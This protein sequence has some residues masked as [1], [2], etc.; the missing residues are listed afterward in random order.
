M[1]AVA[2]KGLGRAR[3]LYQDRTQ[4]AKELKAEGKL[5]IGYFCLY[6][7]L[8]ML[9]ALDIVPY[10]IFGSMA[11]PITRAD[12]CL[13]TV[14]CPFVRSALD[15][16]LKGKYD[17]L[18]GVVMC[19]SCEVAEKS[20]HIWRTF[21]NPD[22]FYFIDAPH[23][24]HQ[25]AQEQ[26]K[27][28][29]KG[30]QKTLESLTGQKLTTA[31]LKEAVKT[32]NQQRS[33]V[34]ELYDLTKPDPPLISGAE[35]M[36]VMVSLT[37]LPIAEGSELLRQV[38]AEVKER[39]NGPA[40]KPARLLLWGSIIDD[41]ALIEMIENAG[42]HIVVDDTC[43]GSRAHFDDVALTDDPLDGLAHRYLVDIKCPRTF[44]DF[45]ESSGTSME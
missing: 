40:Q 8:E 19:H 37:G 38:I 15:L 42:A 45:G 14:V 2:Q 39:Q 35:T 10:R 26:F 44:R 41:T 30:F 18:N 4:R 6:P 5:V 31:S 24:V 22:Y 13:P 25:A 16:G 17:L 36:Q 3:E 23:T 11:E 27:E 12:A 34:R 43:V 21:L 32:H 20:A 1:T 29:L 7:V 33:L 28:Q 9:T